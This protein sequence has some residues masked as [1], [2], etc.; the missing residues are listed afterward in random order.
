M[1]KI[2][3]LITLAPMLTKGFRALKA[4]R[5]NRREF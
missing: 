3:K 5:R 1:G 4:N 2:A